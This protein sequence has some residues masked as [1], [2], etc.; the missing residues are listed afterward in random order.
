MKSLAR[1]SIKR[2]ALDDIDRAA[3]DRSAKDGA[4]KLVRPDIQPPV[5]A[6]PSSYDPD[7]EVRMGDAPDADGS[8]PRGK[9][10]P[11]KSMVRN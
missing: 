9:V 2:L 7:V 10:W 1:F 5:V 11:L 4:C 8:L 6:P 3:F